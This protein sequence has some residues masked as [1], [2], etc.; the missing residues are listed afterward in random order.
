LS[1]FIKESKNYIVLA[2]L[3]FFQSFDRIQYRK[4]GECRKERRTKRRRTRGVI[5]AGKLKIARLRTS[6]FRSSEHTA[7]LSTMAISGDLRVSATL[8]L[9]RSHSHSPPLRTAV[10]PS[11]K[12]SLFHFS[13]SLFSS[14]EC[15]S[16][17]ITT[18]M[19]SHCNSTP[20][21]F[22]T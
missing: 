8:P 16:L 3:R 17:S 21:E 1:I 7:K 5:I 20:S 11:P 18:R 15:F 14:H 9:Y 13:I 19:H 4:K 22:N 10:V 6:K 2:N 12:V